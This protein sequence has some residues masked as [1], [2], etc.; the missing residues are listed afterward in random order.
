M[1]SH[2]SQAIHSSFGNHRGRAS[3]RGPEFYQT[4]DQVAN[5]PINNESHLSP[6]WNCR[7]FEDDAMTLE[8][9]AGGIE[10][11]ARRGRALLKRI[12]WEGRACV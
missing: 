5:P 11:I 9:C 2:M 1:K 7:G 4:P 3:E 8:L 10:F 12:R 6:A